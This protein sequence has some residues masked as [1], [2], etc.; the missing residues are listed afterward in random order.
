MTEPSSPPQQPAFGR[1]MGSLWLYTVLR[2]GL[3]LALWGIVYLLGVEPLLAALIAAV[4]SVPL[5]L[6]LLARPR[7]NFTRQLELRVQ[8]RQAERSKLDSRLDEDD[9][10]RE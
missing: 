6:V 10:E 9:T 1:W 4:V 3:F 5:S 8:A 7:D 2:I